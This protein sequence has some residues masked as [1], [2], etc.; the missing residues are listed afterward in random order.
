MDIKKFVK[1]NKVPI[2]IGATLIIITIFYFRGKKVTLRSKKGSGD[3]EGESL[4]GGLVFEK[5]KD[6][7]DILIETGKKYGYFSN[8]TY[9]LRM[10]KDKRFKILKVEDGQTEQPS[11]DK[12]GKYDMD[13]KRLLFED[14]KVLE[15]SSILDVVKKL[16]EMEVTIQVI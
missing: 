8:I 6:Y 2:I 1:D 10:Y 15:G 3:L 13:G 16:K 12:R 11:T 4:K 5:G 7:T 9:W 14:G